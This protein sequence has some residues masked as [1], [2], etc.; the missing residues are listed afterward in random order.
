MSILDPIDPLKPCGEDYKYDDE[1]LEVEVEIEKSFNATSESETQWDFVVFRCEKILKENTKDLKIASFWLYAHWKMNGWSGFFTILETYATFIKTFGKDL[2]PQKGKRKIK[3]F[4]W[5]E[6]I[7]E[8]PFLKIVDQ[9]SES[10]LERLTAIFSILEKAVP[11]CVE[12]NYVLLKTVQEETNHML[13]T[14]K[15]REEEARRMAEMQAEEDKKRQEE[16]AREEEARKIRRSEEEEIL[17]KFGASSNHVHSQGMENYTPLTHEDIDAIIDPI[18]LLAKSLFEKAPADYLAFKVLFSVTEIILE[19]ALLDQTLIHEDFIPSDDICQAARELE[20]TSKISLQQL[21][22]LQ[23]QLFTRPTWLEGY[24]I[25]VKVLYR[26]E[27]P[28]DALHIE[29]LLIHFLQRNKSLFT[30]DINGRPLIA[31]KMLVWAENKMLEL[32]DNGGNNVEYQRAYQEILT[33][34]KEESIQNALSRLEKYYQE[35]SGEEERFRWRLLFVDF[36][37]DIGDKKLALSLLLELERLIELYKIDKWQP[38]LAITTYETLLKPIMAQELGPN[39]K[40]RIYNKLSILDIQ[41]VI[42]I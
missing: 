40:E 30:L 39:G 28:E 34:K 17:S 26:L 7:F 35:A 29:M 6:K 20:F 5:V 24:Y 23:E 31:D 11:E 18:I 13:K 16:A 1:Y 2:Y 4:E 25:A 8:E 38:E 9:F 42:N 22:A 19:E 33:I 10:E 37:L 12:E 27:K 3:I 21:E 14:C 32:C 15:Q 36:A 41:K